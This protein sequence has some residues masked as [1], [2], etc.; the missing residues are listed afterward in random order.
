M[1]QMDNHIYISSYSMRG[2]H[3]GLSA[4]YQIYKGTK[5]EEKEPDSQGLIHIS[6]ITSINYSPDTIYCDTDGNAGTCWVARIIDA[7][8][9]INYYHFRNLEDLVKNYEAK[10]YKFV[11]K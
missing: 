11:E 10:G 1:E 6:L 2:S 8:E 5:F 7:H 4:N 3:F 9:G